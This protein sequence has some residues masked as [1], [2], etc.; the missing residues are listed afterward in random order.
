MKKSLKAK[1]LICLG[2]MLATFPQVTTAETMQNR[3]NIPNTGTL[4]HELESH[5]HITP[6]PK[7]I[8]VD[9]NVPTEQEAQHEMTAYVRKVEFVCKDLDFNQS[10]QYLTEGKLRKDM[11]FTEMQAL[12]AEATKVLRKK[13]YVTSLA[14]I[15]AQ[16]IKMGILKI[17]VFIGRYGDIEINNHSQMTDKRLLGY[18]YAVRPGKLVKAQELDKSLLIL[19]EIPGMEVKARM[20]PGTKKG[21]AKIV[22]DADTLEKQGG[23]VYIDDYGNKSTGRWRYGLNYHYNNLTKVG[24]QIDLNYLTSFSDLNN[25]QF[26]YSLPV[27][28]DGAISRV[29]YSH[30]NYTLGNR[31]G[32][33]NG[34]GLANTL[35][36]GVTVPMY[37]S[38]QSSSW[39]D[40]SYRSRNLH[41]NL[42]D[43]M[44]DSKKT[45]DT[46][47]L[48]IHGYERRNDFSDTYSIS[49]SMGRLGMGSL[50]ARNTD[51]YDTAGWFSKTNASLYHIQRLDDRWQMHVS[52]NGQ[53]AWDNLDGSEDFYITGP[54]GVRAFP[55]GEAGGDSALLGTLEFRYRTG[56]P[57]LQITAFVDAGR[58]FYNH[59]P[60]E[61]APGDNVQNLAGVGLG[62]IYSKY[63]DW[64]AK[65][66]W[67]T[68]LG[69]HY[70]STE[71]ENVHNTWWFRLVKQF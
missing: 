18:T 38:L 13:G 32:Y 27:G 40:I 25:Y 52:L 50:Y 26:T 43:N 36:L 45:S 17:N 60:L 19:N 57:E 9:M 35:E 49:H 30:M 14:Y 5:R 39:Y 24:D 28:R 42:F 12:A 66:D 71:G 37:R 63:R 31:W 47:Q 68:P 15:P 44:L 46:L 33:L 16:D 51:I 6:R 23:Y 70:S 20:E 34:D 21:T 11:S 54:N 69:N 65:F 4:L 56:L 67:A 1:S 10:L 22:I 3:P 41:D 58:V 62:L 7:K 53:Y 59:Q 64:Y 29:S 55:Q 2:L 48:E 61:S 8:K